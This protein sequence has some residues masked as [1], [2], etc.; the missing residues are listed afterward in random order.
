MK[1]LEF[2]SHAEKDLN[3]LDP[4]AKNKIIDILQRFRQ[5]TISPLSLTGSWSGWYKIRVGNYRILLVKKSQTSW[6]VGYIRHRKEAYR[7]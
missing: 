3:K 1:K 4:S 7:N 6:I 2:T 5:D